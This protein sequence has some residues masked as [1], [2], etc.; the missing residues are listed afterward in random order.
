MKPSALASF[1]ACDARLIRGVQLAI[2]DIL[3]DRAGKQMGILK[4]DA[5][6]AAQIMP[7]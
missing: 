3:H 2:A 6:R 7:S 5:Q 4:H 1:A